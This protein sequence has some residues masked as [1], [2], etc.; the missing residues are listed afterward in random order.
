MERKYPSIEGML[1]EGFVVFISRGSGGFTTSAT[2]CP[3]IKSPLN[4]EGD[5]LIY[6]ARANRVNTALG[7]LEYKINP[8]KEMTVAEG[9]NIADSLIQQ[10]AIFSIYYK[11]AKDETKPSLKIRID[12]LKAPTIIS[13]EMP[14]CLM[15]DHMG[16]DDVILNYLKQRGYKI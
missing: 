7:V 12:C 14:M 1:K 13:T 8:V 16:K 11:R 15:L 6:E 2:L 10:G 4:L 9:K 5:E 3:E